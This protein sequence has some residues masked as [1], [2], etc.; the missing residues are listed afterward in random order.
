MAFLLTLFLLFY[1]LLSREFFM[2]HGQ[3]YWNIPYN[4]AF[5]SLRRSSLNCVHKDSFLWFFLVN[6]VIVNA[7]VSL[8]YRVFKDHSNAAAEITLEEASEIKGFIVQAGPSKGG[9]VCPEIW[10]QRAGW[11]KSSPVGSASAEGPAG[12][13]PGRGK[14]SQWV[15]CI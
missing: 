14:H 4:F 13:A 7:G 5:N 11:E 9:T 10:S 15:T 6:N 1:C 2:W 8:P 12:A 3:I